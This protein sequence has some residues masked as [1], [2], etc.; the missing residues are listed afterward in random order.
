[1]MYP[2]APKLQRHAGACCFVRT[3]AVQHDLIIH[4]EVGPAEHF[5]Q[6][7]KGAWNSETIA[8]DIELVS[9]VEDDN[10]LLRYQFG[11]EFFRSDPLQ[12]DRFQE[13]LPL[14]MFVRQ[15]GGHRND[16]QDEQ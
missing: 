5:G 8:R 10:F 12:F 1:M 2:K 15:I 13:P 7:V 14:P 3:G 6:N 11:V 4:R 9:E 16:C